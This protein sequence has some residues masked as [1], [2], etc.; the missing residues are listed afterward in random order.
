LDTQSTG[1]EFP[2][3]QQLGSVFEIGAARLEDIDGAAES[4]R[5]SGC[6]MI[7]IAYMGSESYNE[8]L[9]AIDGRD[10]LTAEDFPALRST[11]GG[12]SGDRA[13]EARPVPAGDVGA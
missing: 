6:F 11:A 12:S 4:M 3:Q 2:R 8:R 1:Y 13:V 7:G 5:D 10:S 9:H